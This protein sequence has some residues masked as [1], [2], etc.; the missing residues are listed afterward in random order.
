MLLTS[1]PNEQQTKL[2]EF[3]ELVGSARRTMSRTPAGQPLNDADS[4]AVVGFLTAAIEIAPTSATPYAIAATLALWCGDWEVAQV[5]A[6]RARDRDPGN[7]EA[8]LI[9]HQLS[10]RPISPIV[11]QTLPREA[12]L[13]ELL[14][15][16]ARLG[17]HPVA[18]MR[19]LFQAV[20]IDLSLAIRG[21][22]ELS[23]HLSENQRTWI[24]PWLADADRVARLAEAHAAMLNLEAPISTGTSCSSPT[25]SGSTN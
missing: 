6:E 13:K 23:P 15:H 12:A 8:R 11:V 7:I 22:Q 5:N 18:A 17:V 25:W 20:I 16:F 2:A 14:A 24:L 9:L 10:T 1:G 4:K 19:Q 21:L 3:D